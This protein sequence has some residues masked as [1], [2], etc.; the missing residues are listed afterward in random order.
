[1][2]SIFIISI[3]Y[4]VHFIALY[5]LI[6]WQREFFIRYAGTWK[7][8]AILVSSIVLLACAFF[9]A[10]RPFM[11][12]VVSKNE[13]INKTYSGTVIDKKVETV[14]HYGLF[15][16]TSETATEYRIYVEYEY[17]GM[18][19]QSKIARKHFSISEDVYLSY[20]IGDFFDSQNFRKSLVTD[21]PRI[22]EG[23]K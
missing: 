23:D 14:T 20:S 9:F 11:L 4:A 13:A 5:F 19:R 3:G 6:K 1:M 2:N 17:E 15:L 8:F 10:G 21:N 22:N 12:S 18:Y 16:L 7:S